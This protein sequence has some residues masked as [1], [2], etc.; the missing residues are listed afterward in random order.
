M[1]HVQV[2][3]G[4]RS[5]PIYIGGDI[6]GRVGELLKK[7]GITGRVMVF[8]NPT[9]G[10][11]YLEDVLEG[12]HGEGYGV[13]SRVVPDGEEYKTLEYANTLYDSL[14]DNRIDRSSTIVALG[15]GVLGDL[16]GFVAATFKRGIPFV[17][18]PTTLLA[19]VDASVGGKVAVDHPRGKNMIGSFYQ[20]RCVIISLSVLDTLP[21]REM[22][23]GLAEV[24]KY[25]VIKDASLFEYIETHLDSLLNLE[26]N[27]LHTVVKRSCEIKASIVTKDERDE[28]QR[29]L[30][31]FGHTIGHAIETATNYS[32]YRHGEA[33]ALGMI[34][35]TDIGVRLNVTSVKTSE[36]LSNLIERAHLPT[37]IR[38]V[39][40]DAVI[41]FL[42]HD[43]KVRDG[44]VRFVLPRE[45][46]QVMIT[47]TVPDD[48][49]R[50]TLK[51]RS[52]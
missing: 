19:Q 16:A 46:G 20:P 6:L 13:S 28:G 49:I 26:A 34:C 11:M 37:R 15:G 14:M 24:I 38:N 32:R 4:D 33:V 22:R 47:D 5:Y 27:G 17:Q 18:V 7:N 41:E 43:K 21:E 31:N 9:V 42:R 52:L 12:F 1:D 44:K 30:L 29:A 2:E 8:T 45:I 39:S 50:K 25:G 51:E 40:A 23:A 36:R 3:L 35:A 48:V 10:S